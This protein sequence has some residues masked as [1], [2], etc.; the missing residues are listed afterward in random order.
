MLLSIEDVN[1]DLYYINPDHIVTVTDNG[2]YRD[3]YLISLSNKA[4]IVVYKEELEHML[5]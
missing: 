3:R 5:G 4:R 2:Y 1:G